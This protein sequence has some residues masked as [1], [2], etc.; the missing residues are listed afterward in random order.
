MTIRVALTVLCSIL[1]IVGGCGGLPP[2][3]ERTA[4]E[5]TK[6]WWND[7][8]VKVIRYEKGS[9]PR[10]F[11]LKNPNLKPKRTYCITCEFHDESSPTKRTPINIVVIKDESGAVSIISRKSVRDEVFRPHEGRYVDTQTYVKLV[12][13]FVEL[14]ADFWNQT[15]PY[16]QYK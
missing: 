13:S 3:I 6:R 15:C 8:G 12:D 1:F 9:P 5:Y 7:V 2:D 4:I 10:A 16:A 11:L 14:F